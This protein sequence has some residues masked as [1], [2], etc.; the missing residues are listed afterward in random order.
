MTITWHD[1]PVVALAEA[2]ASRRAV[3]AEVWKPG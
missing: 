3:L 2:T 1:D